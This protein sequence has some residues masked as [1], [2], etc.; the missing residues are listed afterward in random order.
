MLTYSE[1]LAECQEQAGGD[2]STASTTLFNKGIN[3]GLHRFRSALKREFS[4]ERKTF[5]PTADQQYYQMPED[6][7]RVD[8]IIVTVGSIDYPL[9]QVIDDDDWYQLNARNTVT[10]TIPEFF[11]IRGQDEYGIYPIPASTLSGAG[12]LIYQAR[13]PNLTVADYTTGDITLTN[14]DATVTGNGTTFVAGMV[15]RHLRPTTADQNALWYKIDTFTSTTALELENVFGGV[16]GSSLAYTIGEIPNIPED[17]HLN[18]ADY[19]LYRYYMRRRDK[20]IA[21]DFMNEFKLG[22]ERAKREYSS[23]TVSG[24]IPGNRRR[25]QNNLFTREPNQVT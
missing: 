1:I 17:F 14:G 25:L 11:Y 8:K 24:Y 10:S 9:K 3:Q 18:L 5:S 21:A 23:K 12:E 16:T 6:A 13:V 19:G 15:G 4:L 20:E 2:T 7:I 22:L